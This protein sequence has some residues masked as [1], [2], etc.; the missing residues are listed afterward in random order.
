MYLNYPNSQMVSVAN[1]LGNPQVGVTAA[2]ALGILWAFG[3]G[4]SVSLSVVWREPDLSIEADHV[5]R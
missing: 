1:S 4:N 5:S 3:L 2:N